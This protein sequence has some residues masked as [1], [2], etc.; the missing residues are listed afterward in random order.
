MSDL[1]L[2]QK[3]I[4]IIL[5]GVRIIRDCGLLDEEMDKHAWEL[6]KKLKAKQAEE[7]A[8]NDT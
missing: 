6:L 5:G 3:D 1:R 7:E 2:D 8:Q 4:K